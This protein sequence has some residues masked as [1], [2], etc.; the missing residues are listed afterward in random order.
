MG[1][2][3]GVTTQ[4]LDSL[5]A[6]TCAYMTMVHPDYSILA[7]RIAVTNLHK[8]TETDYLKIA[9]ILHDY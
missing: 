1:I 4:Q 6:E 2:F 9:T 7:S 8:E 5:A 3:S